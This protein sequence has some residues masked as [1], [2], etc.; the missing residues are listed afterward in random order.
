MMEST[1]RTIR[2][3][4]RSGTMTI[5]LAMEAVVDYGV[6]NIFGRWNGAWSSI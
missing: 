4:M 6:I 1:M 3:E 2:G 5:S